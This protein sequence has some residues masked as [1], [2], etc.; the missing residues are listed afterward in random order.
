MKIQCPSCQYEGT[1][2]EN[3]VPPA[4]V[5]VNCPMCKTKFIINP[6][7]N[8]TAIPD[9]YYS[10]QAN[11]K[12]QKPEVEELPPKEPEVNEV[13]INT[14]KQSGTNFN[15]ETGFLIKCHVCNSMISKNANC[16]PNC[17]EPNKRNNN[18]KYISIGVVLVLVLCAALYNIV[19][20]SKSK[21]NASVQKRIYTVESMKYKASSILA[22]GSCR[23]ACQKYSDD[24][25][26]YLSEGYRVVTSS[27]KEMPTDEDACTCIG[28][29]YVIQ[30]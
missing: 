25:N 16:C 21:I 29:E 14:E 30:K 9:F 10:A 22:W 17:G 18:I 8:S 26:T 12:P 28:T 23:D 6:P 24:I 4:G 27:A 20:S 15:Q 3:K 7:L 13:P 1:V 2:P 11:Q 19:K 5:S